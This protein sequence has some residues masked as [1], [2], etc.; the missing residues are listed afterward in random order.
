MTRRRTV[1]AAGAATGLAGPAADQ[2]TVEPARAALRRLLGRRADQLD[3]SLTDRRG[4][5]TYRVLDDRGRPHI[6]ATTPAT[7]LT[8]FHRYL[9]DTLHAGIWWA[10]TNLDHLPARLPAPATPLTGRA[11]VP[12][13]FALNDTNDGYTGPY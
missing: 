12:H 2:D 10:G 3:L 7:I 1:L 5:D 6:Q 8:G 4:T 9:D 13:R 11:D